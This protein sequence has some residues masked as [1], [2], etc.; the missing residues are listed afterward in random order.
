MK[1]SDAELIKHSEKELIDAINGDLDWAA[2]EKI[3]RDRH[4][5]GIAE[6]IEYRNG[7]IVVH[8]NQ[9]AYSLEFDVRVT[10]SILVDREG[11]FLSV[12]SSGN[13]PPASDDDRDTPPLQPEA[14]T[15]ENKDQSQESAYEEALTEMEKPASDPQA[16][17]KSEQSEH[18][19][20]DASADEKIAS[21]ASDAEE[22]LTKESGS[23]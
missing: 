7:D 5:M 22:E 17:P 19:S 18:A 15:T 9:V 3:F 21:A 8:N 12:T 11:N 20:T 6:D 4:D 1:I 16:A 23:A 14:G 10:L 13:S 2:I